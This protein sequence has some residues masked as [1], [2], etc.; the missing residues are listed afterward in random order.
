[1]D[2]SFRHALILTLVACLLLQMAACGVIIHPERKG[3]T[4]RDRIDPA[5]AILDGIGLL[6]FIIPGLVAYAVDF[7]YGTIYLPEGGAQVEPGQERKIVAIQM[8]PDDM[9]RAKIM[10]AVAERTGLQLDADR[11]SVHVYR[12]GSL[13]EIWSGSLVVI[14]GS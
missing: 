2:R 3:Q 4:T 7:H 8:D 13:E 10:A 6:F 11:E 5:I 1:M 14:P 12:M 9:S